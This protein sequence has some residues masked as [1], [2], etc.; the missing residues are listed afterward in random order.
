MTTGPASPRRNCRSPAPRRTHLTSRLGPMSD[1]PFDPASIEAAT[2]P[3]PIAPARTPEIR[4][5][6]SHFC[7]GSRATLPL[8]SALSW[9]FFA[10]RARCRP[11]G[12]LLAPP[13]PVSAAQGQQGPMRH[14]RLGCPLSRS[15]AATSPP[16][17]RDFAGMWPRRSPSVQES[18]SLHEKRN[19][20]HCLAT[21]GMPD[22]DC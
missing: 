12:G 14:W 22:R 9:Q 17:S 6:F 5:V 21:G 19:A 1:R 15:T 11:L 20:D 7:R 18:Q 3:G 16:T 4:F 13:R 8:V 10:P 2:P